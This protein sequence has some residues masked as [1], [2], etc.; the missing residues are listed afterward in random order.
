MDALQGENERTPVRASTSAHTTDGKKAEA[1]TPEGGSI[2]SSLIRMAKGVLSGL[3]TPAEPNDC[4]P[5]APLVIPE[6]DKRVA[7]Q[8]LPRTMRKR[9]DN[10]ATLLDDRE[11]RSLMYKGPSP[12]YIAFC[13]SHRYEGLLIQL[14]QDGSLASLAM[15]EI[16]KLWQGFE[17]PEKTR[18]I[19][20]EYIHSLTGCFPSPAN[21]TVSPKPAQEVSVEEREEIAQFVP[22]YHMEKMF[23][24]HYPGEADHISYEQK[25]TWNAYHKQYQL[26]V[27][28]FGFSA[29]VVMPGENFKYFDPKTDPNVVDSFIWAHL[30]QLN[31]QRVFVRENVMDS[32]ID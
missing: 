18:E 23:R 5:Y 28:S 15:S 10:L 4:N 14:A 32:N 30:G 22:H 19:L 6:T 29:G 2:L 21:E 1:D 13:G 17:G 31:R 24:V 16:S 25:L 26:Q 12:A 3:T 20:G 7:P 27:F 9:L 8:R 11:V